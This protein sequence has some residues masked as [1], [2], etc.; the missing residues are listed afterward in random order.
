MC[1]Y[2]NR[3]NTPAHEGRCLS[4]PA[5]RQR[6]KSLWSAWKQDQRV[7]RFWTQAEYQELAGDVLPGPR[8]V[9]R[10][11]GDWRAFARWLE[12]NDPPPLAHFNTHKYESPAM[13][14]LREKFARWE[15]ENRRLEA[16][17]W[18]YPP[19]EVANAR[20]QGGRVYYMLR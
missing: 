1:P 4:D 13:D 12:P 20:Q 9:K 11:F 19:L 6:I 3:N 7:H 15:E 17:A 5:V 10:H 14:A 18:R 2:C 16:L 8:T